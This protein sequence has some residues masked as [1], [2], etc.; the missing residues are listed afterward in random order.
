MY[1][2]Y[3]SSDSSS[4]TDVCVY[5]VPSLSLQGAFDATLSARLGPIAVVLS[6]RILDARTAKVGLRLESLDTK[7][8]MR[9]ACA[10]CVLLFFSFACLLRAAGVLLGWCWF[11]TAVCGDADT[12]GWG[13]LWFES[14]VSGELITWIA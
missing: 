4:N 14:M 6:S 11:K 1:L 8:E 9:C 13:L 10:P 3:L 7:L 5:F 2:L 12:N